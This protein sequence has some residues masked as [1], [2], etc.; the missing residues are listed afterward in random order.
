VLVQDAWQDKG[1]GELLTDYG[2]RIARDWGVR[3]I[4]AI[5]TTDDPRLAAVSKDLL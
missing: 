3:K 2:L 5:T 4:T 1:L